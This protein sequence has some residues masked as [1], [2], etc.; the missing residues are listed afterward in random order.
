[1]NIHIYTYNVY[2]YTYNIYIYI[3]IY[4][5]M[6]IKAL[7]TQSHANKAPTIGNSQCLKQALPTKC[8]VAYH[9]ISYDSIS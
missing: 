1:M 8:S 4:I 7:A 5:V 6:P 9:S 2:T 3:Y